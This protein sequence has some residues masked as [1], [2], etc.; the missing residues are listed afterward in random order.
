MMYIRLKSFL[1]KFS[2]LFY[3]SQHGFREKRSTEHAILEITSQIQTNMDRTLYTC[4]IF[5]KIKKAF[6]TVDHSIL[7]KKLDDYQVYSGL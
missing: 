7:L 6:A 2:I 3:D 4:V 5:N 1:E